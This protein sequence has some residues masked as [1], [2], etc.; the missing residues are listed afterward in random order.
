MAKTPLET[1]G[2]RSGG[3]HH[4]FHS[5]ACLAD[6]SLVSFFMVE[7]LRVRQ[8]NS[9]FRPGMLPWKSIDPIKLTSNHGSILSEFT[10]DGQ[11]PL[12]STKEANWHANCLDIPTTPKN[13]QKPRNKRRICS[14]DGQVG[15]QRCPL[16][17]HLCS[18]SRT[19]QPGNF[20]FGP[21]RT[22]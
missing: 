10:P 15:R 19:A 7:W 12:T 17:E 2:S 6:R 14:K 9:L 5:P 21:L 3:A 18:K 11:E 16:I 4:S 22:A 20:L 1:G 13:R 8:W